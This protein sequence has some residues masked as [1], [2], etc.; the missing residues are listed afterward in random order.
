MGLDQVH[1]VDKRKT[2]EKSLGNPCF[3]KPRAAV[4]APTRLPEVTEM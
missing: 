2:Q 1:R 4:T 3:L